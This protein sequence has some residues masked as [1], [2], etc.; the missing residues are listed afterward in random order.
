MQLRG[1][2]G[3]SSIVPALFTLLMLIAAIGVF[4]P[5][6]TGFAPDLP[7]GPSICGN[8]IMSDTTLDRDQGPCAGD[9]LYIGNDNIVL[10]CAGYSITGPNSNSGI[11]V[12]GYNN[13]TIKNCNIKDFE[14]GFYLSTSSNNTVKNN[15]AISTA[16]MS[17]G[18]TFNM[19]FFSNITNNTFNNNSQGMNL[20]S[21]FN[22]TIDNNTLKY[23]TDGMMLFPGSDNNTIINNVVYKNTNNGISA[24][25]SNYVF[26]ANNTVTNNSAGVSFNSCYNVTIADNKIVNSTTGIDSQTNSFSNITNNIVNLSQQYGINLA[27]SI[28]NTIANN[29]LYGNRNVGIYIGFSSDNN[30][31]INNTANNGRTYGFQLS[32][33]SY[34]TLTNNTANS[35]IQG[36]FLLAASNFNVLTNNSAS[37]NP[38]GVYLQSS[39]G[40]TILNNT[41]NDNSLY[42]IYSVSGSNNG[43]VINNTVCGNRGAYDISFTSD[44]NSN[45]GNNI[46]DDIGDADSNGV[47]CL[48]T[49]PPMPPITIVGCTNLGRRTYILQNDISNVATNCFLINANRT[50]LDCQ[51]KKITGRRNGMGIY[52]NFNRYN[53]TVMNCLVTNFTYGIYVQGDF[54]FT[55]LNNT[56]FNNSQYGIYLQF[57]PN[58][59]L[60]NNTA[61]NNDLAG[62]YLD[63]SYNNTIKNNTASNNMWDFSTNNMFPPDITTVINMTTKQSLISFSTD[64]NIALKGMSSSEVPADDPGFSNISKWINATCMG[65]FTFFLNFSY[66]SQDVKKIQ[67]STLQMWKYDGANWLPDG[68]MFTD[69]TFGRDDVNKV[70]YANINSFGP[71]SIFAPIGMLGDTEPPRWSDNTSSIPAT[72]SLTQSQFSVR[73]IDNTTVDK[74][75]FESNFSGS[76]QNYTMSSGAPPPG[77]VGLPPPFAYSA[78]LP[79]GVFYWRSWANDTSDNWNT[80][81]TWMFTI[82]KATST[83]SLTVTPPTPTDYGTASTASCTCTSP[84]AAA[85]LYRN[86]STANNENGVATVLPAGAWEY[87]CNVSS[88][89]NYSVASN[90]TTYTVEQ[91]LNP[92]DLYLNNNH[93]Q[94]VAVT[95][96]TETNATGTAAFGTATRK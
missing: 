66:S 38:Y 4:N 44:S 70:V 68:F 57:G 52:A 28:N 21:S 65:P 10:D 40:T 90:S 41:L 54:N 23:N 2:S 82:S 30:T 16:P 89:Q 79:A 86:D 42:G 3:F 37:N 81:D 22:N 93:N 47:T 56:L 60:I 6:V 46:C 14:K 85:N 84:E 15:T 95:Q 96:G 58:N 48:T 73:W 5:N 45:T 13:I 69:G 77:G 75:L 64:G 67:E 9:G 94:N 8:T 55:L 17:N 43:I 34:N 19:V 74:V 20:Q 7:L 33:N 76:P 26:I 11:S 63:S 88:S 31:L 61:N 50:T 39:L 87:V 12:N 51:G 35:N 78:T 27:N 72:Y 53:A 18:L 71:V 80:S 25:M 49:C 1:L 29:T 83:C 59:T 91:F 62:I 24:G 36:G 32:T 92:V